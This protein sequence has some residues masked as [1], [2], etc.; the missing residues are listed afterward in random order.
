MRASPPLIPDICSLSF[1]VAA[2]AR[3]LRKFTPNRHD[4]NF[5]TQYCEDQSARTQTR[6]RLREALCGT[7]N[8]QERRAAEDTWLDDF[9]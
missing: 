8:T 9:T 1:D 7:E 3:E 4:L 2:Q 6:G 5:S